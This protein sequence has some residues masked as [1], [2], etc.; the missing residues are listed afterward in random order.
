MLNNLKKLASDTAVYGVFMIVGR[1]LTF[2]LTPLYTNYLTEAEVGIVVDLFSAIAFMNILYT[3]GMESAYFR[4][5]D[6]NSIDRTR[7][8]FSHSFITI[9]IFSFITSASII[10][11]STSISEVMMKSSENRMYIILA[12]MIPFIDTLMVVPYAKL[13]MMRKARKF[14]M[15]RFAI[16]IVGVAANIVFVVWLKMGAMGVIWA[17]ITA[18]VFGVTMFLKDIYNSL[19]FK[20]DKRLFFDMLKFGLPTL[21]ASFSAMVLQVADR[22]ILKFMT[23]YPTLAMYGV[24]YKLGIPMMMFVSVFEYAWKPF[25]LNHYEEEDSKKL[26]ARIFTYFTIIASLIFLVTGFFMEY[27]VQTPFLGGKLINPKFWPG[28]DIIP[29]ILGGYFFNGVFTNFAAGCHI[30]KKTQYLPL[31]FGI[32]A[33]INIV[34][35]ILLIPS[36]GYWAS[37]WATLAAYF[38]SAVLMYLVTLKIYPI[39]YEWRRVF[40]LIFGTATVFYSVKYLTDDIDILLSII[41][42]ALSIGLFF[43]VLNLLGFYTKGELSRMKNVFTGSSGKFEK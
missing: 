37:A 15:I 22:Q 17:G 38:V 30:T 27:A 6:K 3:F 2:L 14:A 32:A 20:F 36:M 39:N 18:S 9:A 43:G 7:S 11:F 41:I 10:I 16:V 4:F 29:I 5:Y 26:F 8:A 1:F 19:E 25:Y 42:R 34:M 12:A 35:N 40:L 24:N 13:R 23:D 21:P 28:M 31:A 33:L